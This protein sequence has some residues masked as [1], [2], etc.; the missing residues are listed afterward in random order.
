MSPFTPESYKAELVDNKWNWGKISPAGI[1]GCSA[2]VTLNKD[3]SNENVKVAYHSD[4]LKYEIDP[5]KVPMNIKK[6]E[7]PE[8]DRKKLEEA[9]PKMENKCNK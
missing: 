1:N 4:I 8:S 7:I 2:N 3:G 5:Q 6:I 9:F